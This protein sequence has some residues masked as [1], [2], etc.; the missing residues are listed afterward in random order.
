MDEHGYKIFTKEQYKE[1]ILSHMKNIDIV[2]QMA[3]HIDA[4]WK[5]VSKGH[6]F[7]IGVGKGELMFYSPEYFDKY[8]LGDKPEPGGVD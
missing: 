3:E 4:L 1:Y 6:N 7:I 2:R 5:K 8:I